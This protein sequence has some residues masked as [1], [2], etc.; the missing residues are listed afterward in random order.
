MEQDVGFCASAV[1]HADNEGLEGE[2]DDRVGMVPHQPG[3]GACNDACRDPGSS[4]EPQKSRHDKE[5]T[6]QEIDVEEQ[7]IFEPVAGKSGNSQQQT[8]N[9]ILTSE[10]NSS[11]A[12][13]TIANTHSSDAVLNEAD[14][15]FLE[16]SK[17]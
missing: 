2:N 16:E 15:A 3:T 7:R 10:L 8:G 11:R 12:R 4:P 14:Q 17:E 1:E 5:G 6:E 13:V 9:K